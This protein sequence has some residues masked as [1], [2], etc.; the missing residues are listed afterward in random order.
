MIRVRLVGTKCA[1]WTALAASLGIA[2]SAS[3]ALVD[4][5]FAGGSA[6]ATLGDPNIT[7]TN[8]AWTHGTGF[9]GGGTA[10][11]NANGI[12]AG[13]GESAATTYLTVSVTP[14]NGYELNLTPFSYDSGYA[15]QPGIA[16]NE[17]HY[18]VRSDANGDNFATTFSGS[19]KSV[20]RSTAAP[21]YTMTGTTAFT[22]PPSL[23]HLTAAT[24]FRIYIFQDGATNN[25]NA[26]VDNIIVDGTVAL[27]PEPAS[28]ISLMGIGGLA[29]LRRRRGV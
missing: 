3:A 29:L 27:A 8:A 16:G 19:Q 17:L 13:A 26:R 5:A 9:S 6:A 18:F 21:S 28:V 25:G 20:D 12:A 7:A 11:A 14:A 23:S 10:Y 15:A 1:M 22:L 4:Y 2:S 24:T